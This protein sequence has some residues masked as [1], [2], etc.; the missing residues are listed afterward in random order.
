MSSF[1][2]F[3][4]TQQQSTSILLLYYT[5]IQYIILC[6]INQFFEAR[7]NL[8]MF[9]GVLEIQFSAGILE[10]V[11]VEGGEGGVFQLGEDP[12]GVV[13]WHYQDNNNYLNAAD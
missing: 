12:L 5:I 13:S 6:S 11:I 3:S 8:D 4:E 1:T 2:Y 9:S 7:D 10:V